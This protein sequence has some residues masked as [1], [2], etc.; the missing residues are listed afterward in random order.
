M[1][2]GDMEAEADHRRR[3]WPKGRQ[4][5]VRLMLSEAPWRFVVMCVRFLIKVGVPHQ[6]LSMFFERRCSCMF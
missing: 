2:L 1:L 3:A 5:V 6:R 4:L